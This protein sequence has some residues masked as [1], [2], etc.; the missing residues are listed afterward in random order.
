[1]IR[2]LAHI[3]FRVTD[4]ER[5]LAFYRD[6][7]GLQPAFDFKDER[8]RRFGVYLHV[9]DRSFIELFV[10]EAIKP[11]PDQAY[12]HFCL[13]V[14]DIEQTAAEL[15]SRGM[16]VS[17]VKMGGDRSWQAWL[18]DPDGNRIELH[19]YTPESWQTPSLR[20]GG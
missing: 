7:L 12:Q 5:S 15:R 8:G 6:E 2:A 13:E 4:L 20:Q 9:G 16:E 19:Q 10:T 18:S 14:D 3:C 11:A 1:M 17:D